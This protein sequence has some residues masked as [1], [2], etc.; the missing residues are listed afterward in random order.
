MKK[1]KR[2]HVHLSKGAETARKV[3]AR[4][5]T[6][7]ILTVDAGIMHSQGFKFFVSVNGVWLIDSVPPEFL[8]K[9]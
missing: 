5:G 1:G 8:K 2:H 3:A 6:P 7:V 4:R 9:M